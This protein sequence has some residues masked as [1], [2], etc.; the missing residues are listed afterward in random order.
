M[1]SQL[2][3]SAFIRFRDLYCNHILVSATLSITKFLRCSWMLAQLCI[4]TWNSMSMTGP[5][6]HIITLTH[7]SRRWWFYYYTSRW[8]RERAKL[9]FF[10]LVF[11]VAAF[12]I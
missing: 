2:V 8:G 7:I 11:A 9:S 3:N 4:I 10:V 6:P 1:Q 5:E 12:N